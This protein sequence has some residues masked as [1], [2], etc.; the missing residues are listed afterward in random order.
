MKNGQDARLK[1]FATTLLPS[2]RKHGQMASD[3]ANSMRSGSTK[4]GSSGE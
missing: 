1:E 2:I 3:I 4:A